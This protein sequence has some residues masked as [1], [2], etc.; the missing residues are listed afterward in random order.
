M[1]I[2]VVNLPIF[3]FVGV[4]IEVVNLQRNWQKLKQTSTTRTT[5]TETKVKRPAN[6]ELTYYT[7]SGKEVNVRE[8][9][10]RTLP[11]PTHKKAAKT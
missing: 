9:Q 3:I 8:D 6:I 2:E 1:N 11:E 4:N 5:K 10:P 7:L